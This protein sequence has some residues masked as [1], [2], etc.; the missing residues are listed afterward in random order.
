M[1]ASCSKPSKTIEKEVPDDLL[2]NPNGGHM[3]TTRIPT[4]H[5]YT[6]LQRRNQAKKRKTSTT[7]KGR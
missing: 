1:L 3:P 6:I 2:V 7:R 5:R 4:P